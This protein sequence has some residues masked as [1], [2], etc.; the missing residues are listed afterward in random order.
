ML[1]DRATQS[2]AGLFN[3]G[4]TLCSLYSFKLSVNIFLNKNIEKCFAHGF[5]SLSSYIPENFS[6]QLNA[7]IRNIIPEAQSTFSVIHAQ[8]KYVCS[9]NLSEVC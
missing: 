9:I 2:T 1:C 3:R 4:K 8:F 5:S 6:M 7:F